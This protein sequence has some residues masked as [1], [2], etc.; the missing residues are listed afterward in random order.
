VSLC[1]ELHWGSSAQP[2]FAHHL[3]VFEQI[4]RAFV[5]DRHCCPFI[6]I[7][8]C[9]ASCWRAAL[10]VELLGTTG[11][12]AGSDYLLAALSPIDQW[13]ALDLTRMQSV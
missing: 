12:S 9:W 6:P 7:S 4:A 10:M 13:S 8:T 2:C 5:E 3:T 11:D 1:G